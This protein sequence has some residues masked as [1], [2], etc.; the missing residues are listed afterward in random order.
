MENLIGGLLA[1]SSAF[2]IHMLHLCVFLVAIQSCVRAGN[3]NVNGC[4]AGAFTALQK[5][6][7]Q[8]VCIVV[9]RLHK[10]VEA[11]GHR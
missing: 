2:G 10:N 4:L 7:G 3:R 1:Y 8:A 6:L 5:R 11:A 9:G